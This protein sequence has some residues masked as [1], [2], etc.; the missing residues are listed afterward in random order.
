MG[1]PVWSHDGIVAIANPHQG[2]VKI[3]FHQGAHLPDPQRTF[4]NG[5]DGNQWRAIDIHE[6]DVIDERALKDLIK[7]A[8]HLNRSKVARKA[9]PR[10]RPGAPRTSGSP[11]AKRKASKTR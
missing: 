9:P 8:V 4:N 5:L 1:T 2:K 6:T 10:R 7:A 11:A 3:T